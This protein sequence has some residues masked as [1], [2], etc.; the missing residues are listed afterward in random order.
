MPGKKENEIFYSYFFNMD[1]SVDNAYKPLKLSM[2]ILEIQ[3]EGGMSQNVDICLTFYFMK[4]R[5]L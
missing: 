3:V 2:C 5:N 4:R 1:I